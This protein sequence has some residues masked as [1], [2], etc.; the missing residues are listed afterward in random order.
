MSG[1]KFTE[2][3]RFKDIDSEP[4]FVLKDVCSIL[5]IK[6][7]KDWSG[8][9]KDA[10]KDGVDFVDPIGRNQTLTVINEAGLNKLLFKSK[11]PEAEKLQDWVYSEVLPSIRKTGAYKVELSNEEMLDRFI[12]DRARLQSKV[13][14]LEETKAQISSSREASCMAKYSHVKHYELINKE[15]KDLS[16]EARNLYKP[17]E[18]GDM[19][20]GI[21]DKPCSAQKVN[22]CLIQ[23]GLQTEDKHYTNGKYARVVVPTTYSH[24]LTTSGKLYAKHIK[25]FNSGSTLK[26]VG[27]FKWSSKVVQMIICFLNKEQVKQ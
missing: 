20:T 16:A 23:L 3:V 6:N 13:K 26:L 14:Q 11:K 5:G 17:K 27:T 22:K 24:K 4:W 10:W 19:I 25:N 2:L 21:L 15:V 12:E 18:I 8:K 7:H 9:I 1:I